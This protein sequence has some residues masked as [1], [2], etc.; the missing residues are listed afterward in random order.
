MHSYAK[1]GFM[2]GRLSPL[3]DGKIQAFPWKNWE[4]EFVVANEIK[5]QL[6]EWTLDQDRLYDN[7]LLNKIGQEQILKLCEAYGISIPS[8]TGDC[9][10]QAPFWKSQG[11]LR[12]KLE[13]DFIEIV[14]GCVA[15][16][17]GLIVIPLVDNGRLENQDQEDD[18]IS[19]LSGLRDFLALNRV[20]IAFESDYSPHELAR[21]IGRLD[22]SVF[23]INYDIGNSAALGFSSVDEFDAY[24][25]RII[26]VHVKD[27][28][29]GG[30]TV[31][32]GRGNVDF[33]LIFSGLARLEYQGN[34]ILQTARAADD[35]HSS[36]LSIYAK[37]TTNWI[38]C[39]VA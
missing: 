9:F 38:G 13:E 25:H 10:M 14:K 4:A 7:P 26:N 18:L 34:Y 16:G 22:S 28:I 19:F 1:V 15:V 12:E 8:L 36:V 37:M 21:L 5:I 27:R 32:L 35:D 11:H 39:N 2:Q 23:G 29:L 3:I 31:P 20:R 6:M 17:I 33:D 30:A 24:G